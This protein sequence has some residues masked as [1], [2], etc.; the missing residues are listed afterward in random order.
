MFFR[1]GLRPVGLQRPCGGV[2]LGSKRKSSCLA[3]RKKHGLLRELNP[4]PLAP[5]ARIM[6]LDQAAMLQCMQ[7]LLNRSLESS[8][9]PMRIV[10]S[11]FFNHKDI[12]FH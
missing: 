8:A 5:E 3:C 1:G 11:K 2:V 10:E 7:A 6:P 9:A 12:F 4:G